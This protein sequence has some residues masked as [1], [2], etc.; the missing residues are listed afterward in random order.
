MGAIDNYRPRWG[1]EVAHET[2]MERD[3]SA[4]P[5]IFRSCLL[6]GGRT[7]NWSQLIFVFVL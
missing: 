7:W 3:S 2:L 6:K 5:L 4:L 1:L